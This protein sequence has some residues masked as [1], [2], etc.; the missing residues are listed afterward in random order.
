M[1]RIININ[2][3]SKNEYDE[4]F[5]LMTA[6]KKSRIAHFRFADDKKRSVFGEMLA[7]EMIS[8]ELDIPIESIIIN[9]D[10]NGK[11][12]AENMSIHFNISHSGDYVLCAIGD[13]PVGVDIEQIRE[14]K[15]RLIDFVCTNEE[16]NYVLE[17]EAQ[18]QNR[19]FEIWTAKEAYFKYK[20]TG[21]TDVKSVNT[22]DVEFKEHIESFVFEDCY[23]VSIYS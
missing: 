23:V 3:Y 2:D 14:I 11:P 9:K 18:K 22:L 20:G 1:Y 4:A 16:K 7:K 17:N 6:E 12:Y 21:I 8:K 10:E 15:S 19:F 5:D 13:K